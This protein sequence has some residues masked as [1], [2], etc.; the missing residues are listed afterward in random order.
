MNTVDPRVIE[1][2]LSKVGGTDFENF[3]QGFFA[4]T[5]GVDYVPMGGFHD[6][7]ADGALDDRLFEAKGTQK[8]MQASVTVDA[9]AK[10][11]GTIK[12]LMEFGRTPKSLIYATSQKLTLIDKI[13][14][15]LSDELD[16]RIVIRDGHFFQHQIN[17]T[18]GAL[19]SYKSYVAKAASYLDH[20]GAADTVQPILGLPTKTLCVFIGQELDRIRG[21]TELL[22]AVTD[23]LILWALE[24]TDPKK[25]KF[26]SLKEIEQRV[27]EALPTSKAF[28]KGVLKYRMEE[29]ISKGK[30]GRKVNFHRK[31][32]GYCL[33]FETRELI[34]LENIE[35]ES[36][37]LQV[38]ETFRNRATQYD[39][40]IAENSNIIEQ[41]VKVCHEVVHKSFHAQGLE[42][43]LFLEQ[44]EGSDSNLPSI[45]DILH[46]VVSNFGLVGKDAALVIKVSL[47]ILRRTFY[48]STEVERIYLRKLSRTYILLFMLKNEPKIVDYFRN[49]TANF[50]LYVGSDLIVRAL[51]E[52]LLP[53]EDQMTKNALALLQSSG[54][55]LI[56]TDKTLD[57]VWHHIQGTHFEFINNYKTLQNHITLNI[58]S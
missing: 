14:E 37:K 38:S 45:K 6:G 15:D 9:K 42:I 20:V 36:L 11:R 27:I 32:N 53:T 51:S 47:S 16:C 29:L 33:P 23:S 54:S 57:E 13:Q 22:E 17:G 35:D 26:R 44:V 39:S 24:G 28:L 7:G 21:K 10:I 43:S 40:N 19:Q 49:M 4:A 5:M 25:G 3:V 31:E 55:D 8:I 50:N 18:P 12:R 48:K 34:R 30:G 52:K 2:A 41:C 58:A 1:I 56:L 46:E